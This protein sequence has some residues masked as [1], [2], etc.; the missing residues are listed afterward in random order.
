MWGFLE[1]AHKTRME[2]MEAYMKVKKNHFGFLPANVLLPSSSLEAISVSID[3]FF[4]ALLH[5]GYLAVRHGALPSLAGG[6]ETLDHRSSLHT[7]VEKVSD[8]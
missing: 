6:T 4:E 1:V 8:N 3:P 5:F 2:M 7:L